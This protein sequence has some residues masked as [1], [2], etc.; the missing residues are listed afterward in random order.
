MLW[1]I[2]LDIAK[3]LGTDRCTLLG[4][5]FHFDLGNG[6]WTVAISL[7]SMGR[8]RVDTCHFAS[9]FATRWCRAGDSAR[10]LV[11]VGESRDEAITARPV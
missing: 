4:R 8:V 11:M 7:D 10:L 6:D 9:V 3:I 2:L 5:A 1:E